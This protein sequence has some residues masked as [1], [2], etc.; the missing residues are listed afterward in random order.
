MSVGIPLPEL[1]DKRQIYADLKGWL[2]SLSN[3]GLARTE[4]TANRTREFATKCIPIPLYP[5][6]KH[7]NVLK[8]EP[9]FWDL[10]GVIRVGWNP[11]MMAWIWYGGEGFSGT[12]K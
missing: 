1:D 7:G 12:K 8:K 6:D 3:S 5:V 2:I 10:G 4:Y 11:R 9:L